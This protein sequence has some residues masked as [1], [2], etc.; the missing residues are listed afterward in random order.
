MAQAT[1]INM[2][3][4]TDMIDIYSK[5]EYPADV[6][7]N[8]YPNAFVFDGV[9]CA[10]FEG[11]LQSLK[12]RSPAKQRK[13]CALYGKTAKQAGAKKWAWKVFGRVYW[14]GNRIRR[15]GLVFDMLISAAY[16]A[17]SQNDEWRRAL[18]A[19]VGKELVH[20]IG[21]HDKRVT[22]LTEEEFISNLVRIRSR[23]CS[24]LKG[25]NTQK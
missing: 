19:T 22:V 8:F 23:L 10:S 24:G 9:Q 1:D 18:L 6:L 3:Q 5:G 4:T 17:L 16:D 11:F 20:S 15:D 7:S 13:I 25:N 14:Q 12:Y 21:K 2:A